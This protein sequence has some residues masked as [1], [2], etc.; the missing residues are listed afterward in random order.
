MQEAPEKILD[1]LE[2]LCFS[3]GWV[4]LGIPPEE[5]NNVYV[6]RELK[7]L[8]GGMGGVGR[9]AVFQGSKAERGLQ[10]ACSMLKI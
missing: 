8:D 7:T 1:S 5:L 4:R 2:G 10:N 9:G 6:K 3:V